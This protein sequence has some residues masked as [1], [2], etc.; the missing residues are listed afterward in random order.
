MSNE[1]RNLIDHQQLTGARRRDEAGAVTASGKGSGKDG[2]AAARG[3]DDVTLTDTARH[4]QEVERRLADAPVVDRERVEQIRR[5]I[6]DGTYPI[7]AEHIAEKLI[8]LERHL[9]ESG[10]AGI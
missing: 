8:E 1:I 9:G 5:A 4:V 10:R 6:A 3:G 2:P 7:R